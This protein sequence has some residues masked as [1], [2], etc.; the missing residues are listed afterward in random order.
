[1][2]TFLPPV[3]PDIKI[4]V[5]GPTRNMSAANNPLKDFRFGALT[6]LCVSGRKIKTWVIF[7]VSL[8]Q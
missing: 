7:I 5:R 6:L 8:K 2:V 3:A 4:F 1:M